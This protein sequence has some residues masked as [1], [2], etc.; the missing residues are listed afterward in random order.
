MYTNSLLMNTQCIPICSIYTNIFQYSNIS[1][2]I[3]NSCIKEYPIYS[4][5]LN[6]YQYVSIY[7]NVFQCI[8]I[9]H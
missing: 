1:Q 4:N 7:T 6:V 2:Y 5:V 3:P 9:V 8:P